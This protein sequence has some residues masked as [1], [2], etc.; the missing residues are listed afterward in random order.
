MG[1]KIRLSKS[2][3]VKIRRTKDL[4]P[5]PLRGPSFC[6][7]AFVLPLLGQSS[8][9]VRVRRKVR[10]HSEAVDLWDCLCNVDF[11]SNSAY[12]LNTYREDW[13]CPGPQS[14]T[15]AGCR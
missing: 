7:D 9:K 13:K 6:R 2:L 11:V 15:T 14:R 10:C 1:C 12:Y 8:D 5:G 4:S 3:E